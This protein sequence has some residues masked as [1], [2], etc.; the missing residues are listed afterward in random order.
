MFSGQ[1]KRITRAAFQSEMESVMQTKTLPSVLAILR[2]AAQR[3]K[4]L[5]RGPREKPAG[6][7]EIPDYLR[8][9]LG[10]EPRVR[11]RGSTDPPRPLDPFRLF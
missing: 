6:R 7:A 4:S 1:F 10:L 11:R 3:F 8:A 5:R 2:A 9:D